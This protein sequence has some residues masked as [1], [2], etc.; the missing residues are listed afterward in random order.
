VGVTVGVAVGVSVLVAVG[1]SEGEGVAVLVAVGVGAAW[2]TEGVAWVAC[3]AQAETNSTDAARARA[4]MTARSLKQERLVGMKN[5]PSTVPAGSVAGVDGP[6]VR[7]ERSMGN[8][9]AV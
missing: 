6:I 8:S 1:V 9:T 2:T 4:T 5:P 3:L 7:R